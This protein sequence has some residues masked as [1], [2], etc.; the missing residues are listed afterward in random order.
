MTT[1]V[2]QVLQSKS[3]SKIAT[4]KKELL[5]FISS[6]NIYYAA[7]KK[8]V[9]QLLSKLE[10]FESNPNQNNPTSNSSEVP[11]KVIVPLLL[12]GVLLVVGIVMLRIKRVARKKKES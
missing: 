1:R 7:K 4:L 8:E 3:K 11:W 12:V 5:E 2:Q 9:E 6:G 10:N